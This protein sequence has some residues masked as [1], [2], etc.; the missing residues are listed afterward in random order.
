[1]K[2]NNI[3]LKVAMDIIFLQIL[4]SLFIIKFLPT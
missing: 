3:M 2:H 1:M 4:V